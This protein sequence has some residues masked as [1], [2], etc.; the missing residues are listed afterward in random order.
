M[1]IHRGVQ[2]GLHEFLICRT[3]GGKL[4]GIGFVTFSVVMVSLGM[5]ADRILPGNKFDVCWLL[6]LP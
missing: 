6:A 3:D 4:L 5:K 1:K 2:E